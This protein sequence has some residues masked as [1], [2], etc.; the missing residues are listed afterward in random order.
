MRVE[1]WTDIVCPFCYIGKN[2]FNR[3]LEDLP[4]GETIE[5]VNRSYE[6]D[7]YASRTQSHNT[8]QSLADKYG[9]S[10]EEAKARMRGVEEMAEKAGLPMNIFEARGANT[11]DAHRLVHLA[12]EKGKDEEVMN[13]LFRGHFVD[14][15]NINDQD[16]LLSLWK[17][18]G[19]EEKEAREALGSDTM[20][21]AVER[22]L[23]SAQELGIRG[24]PY[25][26][27]DG[28]A[29]VSGAQP[30]E[31]FQR[32]YETLKKER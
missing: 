25:F 12:K 3:F 20:K 24:V 2:N 17:E 16:V 1:I 19:L 18:A 8:V 9:F 7:P 30:K 13:A 4:E 10:V 31:V 21:E 28:K 23:S 14:G 27:F 26:L 11:H 15:L 32:V 6:L 5:V 29:E 22:D